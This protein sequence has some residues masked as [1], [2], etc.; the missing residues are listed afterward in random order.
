ML[1]S[2]ISFLR[3]Y[4]LPKEEFIGLVVEV[5]I[6]LDQL[7][8]DHHEEEYKILQ[9]GYFGAATR[10]EFV[11]GTMQALKRI[12]DT[13]MTPENQKRRRTLVDYISRK[14]PD[15]DFL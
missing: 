2:F 8:A 6:I 15:I 3:R 14:N 11:L 9:E 13:V 1:R 7:K 5:K 4:F 10:T 12:P